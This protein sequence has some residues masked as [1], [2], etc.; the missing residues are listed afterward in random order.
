MDKKKCRKCGGSHTKKDG[1]M[2]HRQR[3][4]C[5]DC[6]YVF[7]NKSRKSLLVW[8]RLWEEYVFHKQTYRELAEK[9][10]CSVRTIQ[11]RLDEYMQH[12][13]FLSGVSSIIPPTQPNTPI[14]LLIDTTYFGHDFGVMVFR[15]S[16][17]KEI[18]CT[19]IVDHETCDQYKDTIR[20][21]WEA[22][23]HIQAIVCDG[24]RGLL[25][26]FGDIPT[27]M[28][29]FHQVALVLRATT[30]KPKTEANRELKQLAHFLTRTDKETFMYEL[31]QYHERWWEYLKQ[32][33]LLTNWKSV[34]TH[35][36]TRSAFF[37]LQRNLHYLFTWYDYLWELSIPNTT[38]WLEGIFGHLKAKVSLHRGLKR[39]RKLTLILTL[40]YGKKSL[41]QPHT[42]FH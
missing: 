32:K 8:K 2:R 9:Y 15:S 31:E 41:E 20:K 25:G 17:W 29:Q 21:I 28:C 13:S 1:F 10:W 14:I 39:K 7:Q 11:T 27:Q 42:F 16:L 19:I 18:L 22:W 30:K 33:T 37:S 5:C 24:K 23:W 34:Y 6:G 36:K 35:K 26:W 3:Y 38:N 40:L 12:H 4:K